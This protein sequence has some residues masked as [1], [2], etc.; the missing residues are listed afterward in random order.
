MRSLLWLALV[1]SESPADLP[2]QD[3]VFTI[4]KD[5]ST[6][7]DTVTLCRVRVT[8]HGGHTWPGGRLFFE[9]MALEGGLVMARERG[10]FGLSLG[11]HGSLETVIGFRGLYSR[12]EVLPLLKDPDGS[13]TRR[14]GARKK[15]T[16]S[17]RKK[18]T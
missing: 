18:K 3:L 10:R 6:S 8:N 11:P 4:E 13:E 16:R 2:R 1:L 12:F 9:A 15:Q 14:K 5:F 7:S 17:G